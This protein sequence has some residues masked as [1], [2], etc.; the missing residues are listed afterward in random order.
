MSNWTQTSWENM[1]PAESGSAGSSDT[2]I[3]GTGSTAGREEGDEARH[4]LVLAIVMLTDVPTPP[5]KP[6]IDFYVNAA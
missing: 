3:C 4:C 5:A 2:L 1:L 6:A